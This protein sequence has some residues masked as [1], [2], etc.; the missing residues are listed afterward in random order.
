MVSFLMRQRTNRNPG[1]TGEGL[2]RDWNGWPAAP[3]EKSPNRSRAPVR[4][5]FIPLPRQALGPLLV[6]LLRDNNG[7]GMRTRDEVRA[8]KAVSLHLAVR[9]VKRQE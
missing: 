2:E 8:R 1:D 9:Q 5:I 7:T 6:Y 3:R 4:T